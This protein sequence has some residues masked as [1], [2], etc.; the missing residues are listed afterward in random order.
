MA[1]SQSELIIPPLDYTAI[2]RIGDFQ[3]EMALLRYLD[4]DDEDDDNVKEGSENE[5]SLPTTR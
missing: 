1:L 4:D 5:R 3:E 2:E